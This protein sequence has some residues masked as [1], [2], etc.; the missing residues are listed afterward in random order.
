MLTALH[1]QA[2][3]KV[4]AV[5][6]RE[7]RA[8]R[9][10]RS[11][12]TRE[13]RKAARLAG[14]DYKVSGETGALNVPTRARTWHRGNRKNAHTPPPGQRWERSSRT[15]TVEADEQQLTG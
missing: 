10:M 8:I 5:T 2:P 13:A 9:Q 15:Y 7:R 11:V 6:R 3:E 1:I 12:T 4:T 14:L